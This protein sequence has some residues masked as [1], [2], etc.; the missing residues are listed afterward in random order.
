[1]GLE[2]SNI[3]FSGPIY[4]GGGQFV[5]EIEKRLREAGHSDENISKRVFGFET[6]ILRVNFPVYKYELVGTYSVID[7]LSWEPNMKFDVVIGNPP[8]RGKAALH[9]KFFNKAVDI[10]KDGGFVSFVQPATPYLN[11][12]PKKKA[13]E[14][15]MIENISKYKTN[16]K[17]INSNVFLAADI[18]TDLAIT[19]LEKSQ[20]DLSITYKNGIVYENADINYV[21]QLMIPPEQYSS[22]SIKIK[23]FI[24]KNGSLDDI[25]DYSGKIK[26]MHFQK[27]RGH[28]GQ[29]DFFTLV[30]NNLDYVKDSDDAASVQITRDQYQNFYTYAKTFVARMGLALSKFNGNNHM[31]ELRTVPLVSF[32]KV[33]TDEELAKL[34][35]L[36]DDELQ[37]IQTTLPDYHGVL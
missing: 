34:I 15:E 22:I 17:I 29:D 18:S 33:W 32:D 28:A 12:K 24:K 7:F 36:T 23:E 16:T 11:K 21:N 5:K 37:L 13:P 27:V 1:M 2:K 3:Y 8:Y 9:Q 6:N 4:G 14:A 10:T 35:G 19:I 30:S 20:G 31:G 26:G 25:V